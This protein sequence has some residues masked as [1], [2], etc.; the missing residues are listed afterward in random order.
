MEVLK[1]WEGSG[2]SALNGVTTL[3]ENFAEQPTTNLKKIEQDFRGFE[4]RL[5]IL[6]LRRWI[7]CEQMIPGDLTG[8]KISKIIKR[9]R[10]L[11]VFFTPKYESAQYMREEEMSLMRKQFQA[12]RDEGLLAIPVVLCKEAWNK[13]E[14]EFREIT[15]QATLPCPV[16]V[17][18]LPDDAGPQQ[19][20]AKVVSGLSDDKLLM[21]MTGGA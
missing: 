9:A 21:A 1:A 6:S 4:E 7:D 8:K 17:R 11:L 5:D 13:Y 15:G 12:R 16:D 2:N 19:L 14:K 18:M 10:V 3:L 20:M